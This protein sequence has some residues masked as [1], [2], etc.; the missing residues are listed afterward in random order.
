MKIASP[1]L[2][3]YRIRRSLTKIPLIIAGSIIQGF[4]MGVFLFP[5]SIPSGGGAGLAVL[6]HY[7]LDLPMSLGLWLTNFTFLLFAVHYLG[8][9]SAVGTI[10]VI[11][12]TSVSV[13]FFEVYVDTPFSNVW[14]NLLMGSLFLG[15]GIAILLRQR[16]SNGGIGFVA[17]AISKY[18]RI[19]PGT[20]LFLMNGGI[21][22]ITA[23]VIDWK[24][25]IQAILCQWLATRVINLL[26]SQAFLMKRLF[27]PLA[28]RRK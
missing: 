1:A 4:A 12:M 18:R 15:I 11:T 28:W 24:I 19:N 3:R 22:L 26:Y 13:N 17:L 6:L 14:V 20:S 16:V 21:F 9:F 8:K 7:W 2:R 5:H 23:Y 10:M 25:I 27:Y